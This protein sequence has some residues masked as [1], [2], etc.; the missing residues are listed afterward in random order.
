MTWSIHLQ[1]HAPVTRVTVHRHKRDC[2]G[3]LAAEFTTS[4]VPT[5]SRPCCHWR[6]N[7]RPTNTSNTQLCGLTAG[8]TIST[9]TS[10]ISHR[11]TTHTHTLTHV[12]RRCVLDYR[13]SRATVH[14]LLS[15]CESSLASKQTN[16]LL[17]L[18]FESW[19]AN[20]ISSRDDRGTCL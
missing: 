14:T 7:S 4:I 18:I 12:L 11:D 19:I 3:T 2:N 5:C 6:R 13:G 17:C 15:F 1:Y 10:T 16:L 8:F 9:H 20:V